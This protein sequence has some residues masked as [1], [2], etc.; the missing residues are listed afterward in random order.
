MSALWPLFAVSFEMPALTIFRTALGRKSW[1][2]M[3]AFAASHILLQVTLKSFTELRS[4][5]VRILSVG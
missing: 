5:Q 2:R 3:L 4:S 1:S